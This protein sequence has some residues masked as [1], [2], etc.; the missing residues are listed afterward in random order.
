MTDTLFLMI[1]GILN[2]A[3]PLLVH[4]GSGSVRWERLTVVKWLSPVITPIRE[5]TGR[6]P[7]DPICHRN[8]SKP[9][10]R[11]RITSISPE[12]ERFLGESDP[13]ETQWWQGV[14]P[15]SMLPF[16]T[17]DLSNPCRVSRLVKNVPFFTPLGSKL[18]G[19][20]HEMDDF[21][22]KGLY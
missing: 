19:K 3:M 12:Q 14:C 11:V 13:V 21:A 18:R 9:R 5:K 15:A 1:Q 2:L 4:V 22:S 10:T 6:S 16:Q 7:T 20:W 8:G 17:I